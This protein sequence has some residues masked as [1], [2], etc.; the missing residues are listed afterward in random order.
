MTNHL[1]FANV[2]TLL[3]ERVPDLID[4]WMTNEE[5]FGG[6]P[7][8]FMF[9]LVAWV[10]ERCDRSAELGSPEGNKTSQALAQL[11]SFL[12]EALTSG[13]Q[14]ISDLVATGFLESFSPSDRYFE[15][16]RPYLGQMSLREIQARADWRP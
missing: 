7:Y 9:L 3:A 8:T 4:V 5:N 16:I 10:K 11:F 2:G 15:C 1:T 14:R 6:E 13:N 12:E